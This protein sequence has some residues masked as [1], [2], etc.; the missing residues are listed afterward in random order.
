MPLRG[1]TDA[2]IEL[3]VA[4]IILAMSMSLAFYV[5]NQSSEAQCLAELRGQ[6]RSLE[7]AMVDVAIGSPPTSREAP[8]YMKTCGNIKVEGLRFVKYTSSIYC[9]GCATYS[10]GCWKIEPVYA[11]EKGILKP[12]T[13]ATLCI[14]MPMDIGVEDEYNPLAPP[15]Y[16]PGPSDTR[17]ISLGSLPCPP[18][19]ANCK[20]ELSST[21]INQQYW[22]TLGKADG[23]GSFVIKLTKRLYLSDVSGI[24][25][26]KGYIGVCALSEENARAG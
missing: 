23:V 14:E 1:Q 25:G 16:R 7:S 26:Q 15:D 4:V 18:N 10:S 6:V 21:V 12:V 20:S 9:R 2:P 24:M 11:D 3:L 17:C 5:I 8:F 13:D 19:L 22:R